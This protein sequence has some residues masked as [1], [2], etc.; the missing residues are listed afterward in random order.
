MDPLEALSYHCFHSEKGGALGRPVPAATGPIL[1]SGEDYEGNAL[2]LV[3]HGRVVYPHLLPG[4]PVNGLASLLVHQQVPYP[5]V[6]E[7]PAVHHLVVAPPAA[8][9][10]ELLRPDPVLHQVLSSGALDG[11]GPGWAYVVGGDPVTEQRQDPRPPYVLRFGRLEAH[12]LEERRLLY[13]GAAR[14]PGVEIPAGSLEGLPP[15]VPLEDFSVLLPEEFRIQG[16]LHGLLQLLLSGPYVPQVDG[17][18]VGV[19]GQGLLGQIHVQPSSYGVRHYQ[20]RARQEVAP[21]KWVYPPA[22]VPVPAEHGHS[23]EVVLPDGP[24][25]LRPQGAAVPYAGGAPVAHDVEPQGL[26]VGQETRLP[27]VVGDDP[28]PRREAGLHPRL[29]PQSPLHRLLRQQASA[30]HH[31]RVAGIGAAGYGGYD[32]ATV[33]QEDLLPLY[34]DGNPLGGFLTRGAGSSLRGVGGVLLR[35]DMVAQ[36]LQVGLQYLEESLLRLSEGYP[37]LRVARSGYARL[38]LAHVHLDDVAVHRLRSSGLPEEHVR[39]GVALH[40][41]HVRGIP[42][43]AQEEVECCLIHREESHRGAVLGAHVRYGGPVGDA[44]LFHSGPEVLDELAHHTLLPEGLRYR[45]D[46]IRWSRTLGQLTDQSHPYDL[47]EDHVVGLPQHRGLG[48]YASDT[49]PH[50]AQSVDHGGV[51]VRP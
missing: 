47:G 27:E 29:G 28:A 50:H 20:R 30:E 46:Q 34:R 43:G 7:A 9:R 48:L 37:V 13:V 42:P 45:E 11:N 39:L 22:E 33:P 35:I 51:A 5:D 25:H 23:V 1:L 36:G 40:Q 38:H 4:R 44:Q 19:V 21:G 24:L 32:H 6:A 10:V 14:V 15:L 17:L 41:L 8:E 16:A 49:P 2:L 31:R 18:P 12:P 26:Q 3:P